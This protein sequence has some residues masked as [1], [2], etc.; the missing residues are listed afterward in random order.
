MNITV[1]CGANM[2][3]NKDYKEAAKSIGS[4]IAKK[5]Y[6][7]VYGGGSTGLMGVIADE[8]LNRGGR[9]IGIRP[10]FLSSLEAA[11]TGL[12]EFIR[13]ET[14]TERKKIMIEKGDVYI[15]LPGG[16]GTLEEIAEVISWSMIGKNDKACIFFNI[17]GVYNDL[18]NQFEKMI[19]EGFL[20]EKYK[21]RVIFSQSIEEIES[22]IKDYKI[23][24]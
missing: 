4:W 17:D 6:T 21:E 18:K 3:N 1:Y 5:N 20:S 12:T 16:F 9:V 8:V 11:H 7:L 10:D 14:M 15:A 22:F 2:G 19:G 13:V 23:L 24:A